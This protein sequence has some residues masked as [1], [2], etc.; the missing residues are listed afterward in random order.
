[1]GTSW[2][3]V[4]FSPA[5]FAVSRAHLTVELRGAVVVPWGAGVEAEVEAPAGAVQ[6]VLASTACFGARVSA[7]HRSEGWILLRCNLVA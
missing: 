3:D 7:V 2:G 1:M 4:A 5:A 6:G